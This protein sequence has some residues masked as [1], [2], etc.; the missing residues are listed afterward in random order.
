MKILDRS[1]SAHIHRLLFKTCIFSNV[2]NSAAIMKYENNIMNIRQFNCVPH[3]YWLPNFMDVF[4]WSLPFIAEKGNTRCLF[5]Y[6]NN[7]NEKLVLHHNM[8]IRTQQRTLLNNCETRDETSVSS[9]YS[10]SLKILSYHVIL[11]EGSSMQ[12]G[13]SNRSCG[14]RIFLCVHAG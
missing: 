5:L 12:P 9:A 1:W 11:W 13:V 14:L 10:W 2:L 8:Q 7:N 4:S 3:P 6:H